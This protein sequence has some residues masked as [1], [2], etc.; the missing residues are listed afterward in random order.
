VSR[1][2]KRTKDNSLYIPNASYFYFL[3][4]LHFVFIVVVFHPSDSKEEEE[5]EE[6]K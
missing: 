2:S 3:C 1:E 5:E 6:K 4:Y